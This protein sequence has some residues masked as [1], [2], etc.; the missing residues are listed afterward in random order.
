[1]QRELPYHRAAAIEQESIGRRFVRI[2]PNDGSKADVPSTVRGDFTFGDGKIGLKDLEYRV[3][4]ANIALD[5]MYTMDGEQFDFKGSARLDAR[6]SQMVTGW[7]SLLLKP[8]DPFFLKHGE[9]VLPI[10]ITGTRSNPHIGL[11]LGHRGH[12]DSQRK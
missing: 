8:V 2:E 9:T 12:D 6:I 7:K 11:D 5:G 10:R 4:G 3:P 1:L